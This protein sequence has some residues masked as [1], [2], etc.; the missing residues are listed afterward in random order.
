MLK[1]SRTQPGGTT[2]LLS[3][4]HVLQQ[5]RLA[6]TPSLNRWRTPLITTM[7]FLRAPSLSATSRHAMLSLLPTFVVRCHL[8]SSRR[9][10]L[11]G[12][13]NV[14]KLLRML[15]NCWSDNT[16]QDRDRMRTEFDNM[17][18]SDFTDMNAFIMDH[19]LQQPRAG[20]AEPRH[21][22]RRS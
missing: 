18:L 22:P 3:E 19:L 9:L 16:T 6:T 17:R 12:K 5:M 4:L 10:V 13:T 20:D 15:K 21:G 8:L 14:P 7:L 2:M 1:T 11:S